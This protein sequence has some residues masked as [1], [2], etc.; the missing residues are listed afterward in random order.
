MNV[1]FL[2]SWF[3]FPP[4]NGSKIRVYQL[5][6]ALARQH[7]I[8]L[9]SF[10]ELGTVFNAKSAEGTCEIRGVAPRLEFQ[11]HRLQALLGYFS[12]T[13]RSMIDT[14]SPTMAR[15]VERELT[16]RKYD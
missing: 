6:R 4:D 5:L 9:L 15:L 13:P 1:L 14:Y 10:T 16:Q 8:V 3:P 2:S 7:E 12:P 11:P